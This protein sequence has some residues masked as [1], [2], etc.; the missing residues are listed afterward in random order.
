LE[1]ELNKLE[2]KTIRKR[3]RERLSA[4]QNDNLRDVYF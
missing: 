1:N 2:N 4:M 3:V